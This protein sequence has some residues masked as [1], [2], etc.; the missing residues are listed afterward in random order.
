MQCLLHRRVVQAGHALERVHAARAHLLRPEHKAEPSVTP[1]PAAPSRVPL[2]G[3]HRVASAS[4]SGPWPTRAAPANARTLQ[5]GGRPAAGG[6]GGA[7][8]VLAGT[9]PPTG[10]RPQRPSPA[11]PSCVVLVQC[12]LVAGQGRQPGRMP[13]VLHALPACPSCMP[14]LHASR[15]AHPSCMPWLSACHAY[16]QSLAATLTTLKLG[17]AGMNRMRS[18]GRHTHDTQP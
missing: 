2:T 16:S 8:S 7:V 3:G 17:H 1:R 14:F 11:T 9:R 4:S 12:V 18:V 6:R 5:R 15:S 10:P 13:A